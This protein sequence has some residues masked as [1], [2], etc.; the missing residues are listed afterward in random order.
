MSSRWRCC[1]CFLAWASRRL[2]LSSSMATRRPRSAMKSM[3][4]L[5]I[6]A[7][8]A[9]T[10]RSGIELG[11]PI[12][13][14]EPAVVQIVRRKQPAI[15]VQ[16]VHARLERHLRRPHAGLVRRLVAFLEVAR[17]ARGYHV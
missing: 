3:R 11:V 16:V 12:E 13:I 1:A 4:F 17:R 6:G 5:R 2:V 8:S 9:A 14:V 15:A 7:G 10:T